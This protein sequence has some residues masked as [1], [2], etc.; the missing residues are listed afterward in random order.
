MFAAQPDSGSVIIHPEGM[1]HMIA[2]R[3]TTM[4]QSSTPTRH[5]SA[6][7]SLAALGLK[8]RSLDLFGPIRQTVTIPQK[9][10]KHRPTQKLYDA[11]ITLLAGAQG[12]VEINTRLRSDPVLQRAFGRTSCAEQS[13][14]QETLDRCTAENVTQLEQAVATIL[15]RH[16]HAYRHD[17]AQGWLLLDGDMTGLPCGPKAA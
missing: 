3:T 7:A 17:F 2:R 10:V 12:L 13:V 9:T 6:R 11:F 4:T 15:R 16:G 1:D 8:L 14:V 5:F